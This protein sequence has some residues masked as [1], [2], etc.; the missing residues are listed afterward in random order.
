MKTASYISQGVI[1]LIKR[2]LIAN[3]GEIA[4]RVIRACKEMGIKTVGVYSEADKDSL[5]TKLANEKVCIGPS[6]SS[7][8][9]L[10]MHAVLAACEVTQADAIHPGFG[11]LSENSRFVSICEKLG[12]NFV[13]P[14]AAVIARM[15]DKAEA[16]ITMEKAK[17]PVIPG[18]DGVVKDTLE[19]RIE[20]ERIGFPLLMKASAGGGGKGIRLVGSMSEIDQQFTAAS[21]EAL[22][23]FGDSR[24][25]MEKFIENP[26]HIEVQILAD[27]N[28]NVVDLGERDCSLQIKNQKVLEETPSPSTVLTPKLRRLM[29]DTARRAAK[30]VGYVGAGT[31]EFL[32]DSDGNFYF[33]EMNT[34]I[35]V[36]HPIT[37]EVTGIDLIKWQFRI[38]NGSSLSFTQKSVKSSGHSIEC[39]INAEDPSNNFAPSPGKITKLHLPGGRGV[40]VDTAL[41]EGDMISPF[42]DSMIAKVIT[43]GKDRNEAIAIMYRA[44]GE[45]KIEG[46][47]T[48]LD[49]QRKLIRNKEFIKGQYDTGFFKNVYRLYK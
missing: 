5:H 26:K 36:E 17:I 25:Y 37:E 18:S 23:S 45:M 11:F 30:A 6:P 44:L 34:R 40:R 31:I 1:G 2:V 28:G 3:R 29:G 41:D 13:G 7:E 48:N 46:I 49:F 42:Y 20:A 27:K 12:I 24:I 43:H 16:K 47:K 9:Y 10:D 15:G 33:M 8:S 4:V 14:S 22:S 21:S 39:R 19:A 38:A 32:L 35:Q